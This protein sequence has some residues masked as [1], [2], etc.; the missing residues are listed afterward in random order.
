MQFDE[1]ETA[2]QMVL[3]KREGA[4]HAQRIMAPV[5][6]QEAAFREYF[7]ALDE[8]ARKVTQYRSELQTHV[9]S[10]RRTDVERFF[11]IFPGWR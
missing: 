4:H 3:R 2:Y 5:Q 7:A 9:Y 8:L 6:V 10:Q 11:G 1:V